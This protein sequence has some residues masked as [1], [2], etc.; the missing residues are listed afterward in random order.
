MADI[1]WRWQP[2]R[3]RW[4]SSAR[5]GA[6]EHPAHLPTATPLFV[7]LDVD[8]LDMPLVPGCVSA[9][10][11]GLNVRRA[12]GHI[13]GDRGRRTSRVRSRGGQT[14][15]WTCRPGHVLP[16][17]AHDDRV[18][19]PYLRPTP[20][21]GA[22]KRPGRALTV[23][24]SAIDGDGGSGDEPARLCPGY[25]EIAKW[26]EL[27]VRPR[28]DPTTFLHSEY[29]PDLDR[30]KADI[31]YLGIPYGQ[32]YTTRNRQRP[33]QWS[34]RDARRFARRRARAGALRFRPRRHALRRQDIRAVDCGDIRAD[35]D[36]SRRP[37]RAGR[38]GWY[39]GSWPAGAFPIILGGDHAIPIPVMRAFGSAREASKE[40]RSR[41][42]RST[43]I[44]IGAK[45]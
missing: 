36:R 11:N 7:S 9:E 32:A 15:C 43:R 34:D 21:G 19:R 6:D 14:H 4:R 3:R 8:V 26:Q 10:P 18:P 28:Q 35:P 13:E 16:G 30:L 39:G 44:S 23:I 29:E 2:D 27:T 38:G 42:S 22:P 33:D 5:R 31:A 40:S 45:R 12:A 1:R 20:L 37:C 24:T 41:S 25:T 17:G